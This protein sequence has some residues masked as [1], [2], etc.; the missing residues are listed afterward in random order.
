MIKNL[1]SL[2]LPSLI[3]IDLIRIPHEGGLAIHGEDLVQ[4]LEWLRREFFKRLDGDCH[5]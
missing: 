1:T 5:E 4:E 3:W 2:I